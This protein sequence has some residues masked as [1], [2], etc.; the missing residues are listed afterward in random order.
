MTSAKIANKTIVDDDIS[1]S[2]NIAGTKVKAATSSVRGTVQLASGSANTTAENVSNKL[3]IDDADNLTDE[4]VASESLYPSMKTLNLVLQEKNNE[5]TAAIGRKQD[6]LTSSN[7]KAGTTTGNVVT[8]ISASN[9]VVTIN[10]EKE[11]ITNTDVATNA[12]IADSKIA[13]TGTIASGNANIPTGGTVYTEVRPSATNNTTSKGY[14][15][16]A[17]AATNLT[18][19]DTAIK[20]I[21][22]NTGEVKIPSGSETSTTMASIWVEN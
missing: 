5:L 8:S 12:A 19:L 1:E 6:K 16:A 3:N 9:G 22:P 18:N 21:H 20:T 4:Q 7:V 2:A 11:K 14:L 13:R 15:T 10:K 17:S